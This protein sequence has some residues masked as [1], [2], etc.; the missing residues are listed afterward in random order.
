MQ[1]ET[2]PTILCIDDASEELREVGEML[3]KHF[4][5]KV[6]PEARKGFERAQAI[7]PDLILLDIAMPNMDGFAVCR[8]LKA[9]PTTRS[10]PVIFMTA[11]SDVQNRLEGFRLVAND[12]L[13]IGV[14][15]FVRRNSGSLPRCPKSV[16]RLMPFI[17][18]LLCCQLRDAH[19]ANPCDAHSDG[20]TPDR[21]LAT[22]I[23]RQFSA[24][25]I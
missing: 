2:R 8:L 4:N 5:L 3:S 18:E 12:K 13:T 10:I 20:L 14:S 15:D 9:S 16:I 25:M 11:N 7:Q 17:K 19:S 23:G 1:L 6:S 22:L 21:L 24:R